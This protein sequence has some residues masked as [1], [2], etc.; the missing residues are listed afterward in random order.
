MQIIKGESKGNVNAK[1]DTIKL[2]TNR[3]HLGRRSECWCI[4]AAQLSYWFHAG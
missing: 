4:L 1:M 3:D 2:V